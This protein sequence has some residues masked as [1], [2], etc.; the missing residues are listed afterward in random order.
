MEQY[1]AKQGASPSQ[2]LQQALKKQ[3]TA[4]AVQ[5]IVEHA[6]Q[7]NSPD[8]SAAEEHL[9]L[10]ITLLSSHLFDQLQSEQKTECNQ[11]DHGQ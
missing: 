7:S 3:T 9:A 4:N 1:R 11:N 5:S 6:M 8:R 2:Q 10:H